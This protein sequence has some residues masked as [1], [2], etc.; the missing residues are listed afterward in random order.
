MTAINFTKGASVL[1]AA[2]GLPITGNVAGR[3]T[4][5]ITTA[6]AMQPGVAKA[7]AMNAWRRDSDP[8]FYANLA[9]QQG[10]RADA[11]GPAGGMHAP[12]QLEHIHARVL[13]EKHRRP[14]GLTQFQISNDVPVGARTH[15]VRRFLEDGEAA[16]Y[17]RGHNIPRVGLG[18]IEEEFPVRH[19]VTSFP[20]NHF[21]RLSSQFAN[22]SEEERKMRTA[23]K[24]L[25]R[26][27]N[28]KIWFGDDDHG[29]YGIKNYPHLARKVSGVVF[30]TG[31]GTVAQILGELNDAANYAQ[32]VSGSTF[33]PNRA[34]TS[35]RVR[36]Y[37]MQTQLGTVNDTT[38]GQ[39]FLKNSEH[40]NALES[41]HEMKDFGGT[42]VD[43]I[44]FYNDD[45]DGIS[46]EL[47]QGITPM[48]AQIFGF[49][50]I[51]YIYM[52][53]GGLIMRDSG[54]NL[55]LLVP[56]A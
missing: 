48:P 41:A 51:T 24:V 10:L 15:T 33:A 19:Y 25:E 8:E 34:V 52:S 46:N 18:Q 36:N 23:R 3:L 32:E 4:G 42:D 16:V 40:I 11:L 17:R 28:E 55:L 2:S 22:T 50:S 29:I 26:F 44:L 53:H 38:I 6:L 56:V 49:E 12:R 54:N 9:R 43:G 5:A 21:E 7:D 27:W 35:E 45:V 14:N 37:I 13:E 39:F 1:D 31:G 30:A 47:V 20:S